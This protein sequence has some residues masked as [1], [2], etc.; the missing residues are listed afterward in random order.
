[1]IYIASD[2]IGV[3]LKRFLINALKEQNIEIY[4]LGPDSAERIDYTT[5]ANLLC[6]KVI[7]G[8]DSGILICGTGIGM[9]M[10]ANR[11]KEIRAA[12]CTYE[13]MAEMTRKHN[14]ANVLCL[15]SRITGEE[16]ALA[17]VNKFLSTNFEG[18]R[19]QAR[20]NQLDA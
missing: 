1:M 10:M 5:F 18:G 13:Y 17:I 16:L 19:H 8:E 20:V 9:S 7:Q 14:D 6:D 15:G 2:H 4:D 11:H 12:V 3:D